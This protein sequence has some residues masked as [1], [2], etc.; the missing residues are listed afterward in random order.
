MFCTLHV[1]FLELVRRCKWMWLTLCLV[2]KKKMVMHCTLKS[3][4]NE[5]FCRCFHLYVA[6]VEIL[7]LTGDVYR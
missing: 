6:L 1:V 5:D 3:G 7:T 4:T 2:E